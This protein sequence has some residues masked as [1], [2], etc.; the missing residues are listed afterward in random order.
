MASTIHVNSAS[1]SK[2]VMLMS[3]E[4]ERFEVEDSVARESKIIN[5]MIAYDCANKVLPIPNVESSIFSGVIEWCKKHNEMEDDNNNNEEEE[6]EELRSWAEL[7]TDTLYDLSWQPT[8]LTLSTC[9]TSPAEYLDIRGSI[10]SR[11][12]E[13]H[14]NE[15]EELRPR[16]HLDLVTLC[17]LAW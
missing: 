11:V 7:D 9:W 13:H 5:H 6:E 12:T 14:H 2:V 1:S 17:Y 4:G 16:A 3:M 15:E 10:R 8:S